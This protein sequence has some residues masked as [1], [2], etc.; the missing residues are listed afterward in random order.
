MVSPEVGAMPINRDLLKTKLREQLRFIE[1]SCKLVDQGDSAE[2][3]R[4]ATCLRV[5]FHNTA[6]STALIGQLM[7]LD[8]VHVVSTMLVMPDLTKVLTRDVL[9]QEVGPDLVDAFENGVKQRRFDVLFAMLPKWTFPGDG[10]P[11]HLVPPLDRPYSR[12][13]LTAREWLSESVFSRSTEGTPE[14]VRLTRHELLKWAAN[15]DGGAHVD[16]DGPPAKH[17]AVA[18]E[19]AGGSA[20]CNGVSAPAKDLHRITLRQMGYEVLDS[21]EIQGLAT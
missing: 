13:A 6:T 3:L 20:S 18:A 17:L 4:I 14:F 15:T 9:L 5:L 8:A 16:P 10:Q 7:N 1:N 21:P 2:A 11:P 19:G 12:R